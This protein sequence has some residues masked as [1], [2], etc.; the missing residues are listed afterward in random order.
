[1]EGAASANEQVG[2]PKGQQIQQ[3]DW[4]SKLH[5]EQV[6]LTR[7]VTSG[8]WGIAKSY[9]DRR[10]ISGEERGLN[11]QDVWTDL[12]AEPSLVHYCTGL[13]YTGDWAA[14]T[15]RRYEGK[16]ECFLL[17][18]GFLCLR[19]ILITVWV[20]GFLNGFFP[21]EQTPRHTPSISSHSS[22]GG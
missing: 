17:P 9:G 19:P 21:P 22:P 13:Q 15:V 20:C 11:H 4:S 1:M 6:W 7:N 3:F 10:F 14:R 12:C 8:T 2:E 16:R 18:S 5:M